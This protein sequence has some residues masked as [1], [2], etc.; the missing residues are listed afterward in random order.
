VFHSQEVCRSARGRVGQHKRVG[1]E[2]VADVCGQGR[3]VVNIVLC[4]QIS[5]GLNGQG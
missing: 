2:K 4:K 5:V 3:G 1:K